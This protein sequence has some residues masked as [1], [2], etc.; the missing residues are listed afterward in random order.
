L[1]AGFDAT[2]GSMRPHS[3]PAC[4]FDS[5]SLTGQLLR[6]DQ[7][8]PVLRIGR[9]ERREAG[10]ELR[11]AHL[12]D[13]Q[14]FQSCE[15][16]AGR[17]QLEHVVAVVV[18]RDRVRPLGLEFAKVG[19]RHHAAVGGH[20]RDDRIGN[21][22]AIESVASLR[23]DQSQR[24]REPRIPDD[25]IERRRLAVD[26]EGFLRIGIVAQAIRGVLQIR[27][28]PLGETPALV[29][30][31]RGAFERLLEAERTEPLQQG[32]VA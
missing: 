30:E 28:P 12:K 6:L 10:A 22:A 32:V 18:G 21:F 2:F 9:S 27:M 7:V 24:S 15:A 16:L 11:H 17:R 29:C 26:E 14:H 23:L 4:S 5:R 13:V 8:V 20:L 19:L 1:T 25:A 31:P 3:E